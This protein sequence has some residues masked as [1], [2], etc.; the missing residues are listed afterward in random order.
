LNSLFDLRHEF[1]HDA[2]S[3]TMLSRSDVARLESVAV[4]LPQYVTMMVGAVRL[5]AVMRGV[6]SMPAMLLVEDLLATDWEVAPE[7]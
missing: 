1:V 3:T 7:S 5:A 2:N 6:G 4:I